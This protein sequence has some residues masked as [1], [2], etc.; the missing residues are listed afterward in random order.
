MRHGDRPDG[1]AY[2][3][4]NGGLVFPP[5]HF[6]SIG[7]SK[8][9]RGGYIQKLDVNTGKLVEL[10]SKCEG[11]RLSSPNDLVFD[12]MGGFYFTDLG[13]RFETQRD[14]GGVYY[15]KAD[16]SQIRPVIYPLLMPN[17]IGLSPDGTRLYLADTETS[18][19]FVYEI[20]KPGKVKRYPFPAP[21]WRPRA[22]WPT[23]LPAL[24]QPRRRGQWKYLRRDA[25]YRKADRHLPEGHLVEQVG[26]DDTYVTNVC[27][28]GPDL[29]R[30]LSHYLKPADW[31]RWPGHARGSG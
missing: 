23:G 18:R 24:R 28:G 17:G 10:Y 22:A 27:F 16:G 6:A 26:F 20:E 5:N 31:R 13:K 9:Y 8:D 7:P 12:K 11:R 3:A 19:L 29:A 15:A 21:P 25:R 30:P 4:N 14:H 2:I 1:S